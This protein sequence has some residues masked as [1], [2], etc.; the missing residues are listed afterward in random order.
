MPALVF[1]HVHVHACAYVCRLV[2][3]RVRE[4]VVNSSVRSCSEEELPIKCR[5]IVV[6]AIEPL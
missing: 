2:Y 3:M 4:A 1:V 6:K 5:Q